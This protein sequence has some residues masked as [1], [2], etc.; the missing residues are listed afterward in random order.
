MGRRQIAAGAVQNAALSPRI[1]R[2]NRIFTLRAT[3]SRLLRA[4]ARICA[5]TEI[6][7]KLA[8]GPLTVAKKDAFDLRVNINKTSCDND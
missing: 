2:I 8:R 3:M 5:G 4:N 7:E 6:N 1:A